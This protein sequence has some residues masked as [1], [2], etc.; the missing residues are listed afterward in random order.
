[1]RRSA[2]RSHILETL[3]PTERSRVSKSRPRPWQLNELFDDTL[4]LQLFR[5]QDRPASVMAANCLL[6]D[7]LFLVLG[8]QYSPLTIT[9]GSAL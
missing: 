1:M 9:R 5:W 4:K 6:T 8:S 2:L 7:A 3:E